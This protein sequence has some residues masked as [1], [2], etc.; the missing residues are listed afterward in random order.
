LSS[1][2]L[3]LRSSI[4]V[5]VSIGPPESLSS[6]FV[7]SGPDRFGDVIMRK[8]HRLPGDVDENGFLSVAAPSPL[9]PPPFPP[10]RVYSGDWILRL[11][12]PN[13]GGGLGPS[14]SVVDVWLQTSARA[15]SSAD[16]ARLIPTPDLPGP[17]RED[18]GRK[19]DDGKTPS[20]VRPKNWIQYSLSSY[21][22]GV[23][24]IAVAMISAKGKLGIDLNSSRGQPTVPVHLPV[25]DPPPNSK[26]DLAAPGVEVRVA[27]WQVNGKKP[28]GRSTARTDPNGMSGTSAAAPWVAGAVALMLSHDPTLKFDRIREILREK[29]TGYIEN[30]EITEYLAARDINP[31]DLIGAGV[32]HIESAVRKVAEKNPP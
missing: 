15:S 14:H 8:W 5:K 20:P 9:L 17:S 27:H 13:A 2:T 11:E 19:E 7:E 1:F 21:A 16:D 4:P 3:H 6:E 12:D 23:N 26:P 29:S 31:L 25:P 18:A 22:C 30:D 10:P 24:V 28:I 32:L